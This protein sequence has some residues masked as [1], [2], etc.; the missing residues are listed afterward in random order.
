MVGDVERRGGLSM[1][2]SVHEVHGAARA[3]RGRAGAPKVRVCTRLTCGFWPAGRQLAWLRGGLQWRAE[4]TCSRTKPVQLL[5]NME[6]TSSYLGNWQWTRS[7]N[8]PRAAG[9]LP[10]EVTSHAWNGRA[11]RRTAVKF[12]LWRGAS[13]TG[14]SVIEKRQSW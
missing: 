10:N 7:C 8:G 6:A 2:R 5:E 14:K 3:S 13:S 11:A 1:R 9:L 4:V 12:C